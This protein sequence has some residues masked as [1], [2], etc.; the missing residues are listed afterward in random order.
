MIESRSIIKAIDDPFWSRSVA[1]TLGELDRLFRSAGVDLAVQ[2]CKKALREAGLSTK[3]VTHSVAVTSTNVGHPGYDLSVCQKL[4]L[5]PETDRTLLHGVGCAGG[6]SAMRTAAAMAQSY[7]VRARPARILVFACELPSINMRA[8][9]DQIMEQPE[10]IKASPVLYS[11]G[12]A[13]FVLCNELAEEAREKSVYEMVDWETAT[14]ADSAHQLGVT[15]DPQGFVATLGKDV[16]ELALKAIETLFE[17]L[18]PSFGLGPGGQALQAEDFDWALHPGSSAILNGVQRRYGL[19]DEQLRA[20][21]DVYKK[22]GVSSSCTVLVV[23]DKLRQ[24]G[25]GR[26]K[27][28]ACSFGPGITMEMAILKRVARDGE[29]E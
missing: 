11:D 22:Q 8:D 14:I 4:G 26:E 21:F 28:V 15:M 25:Q 10:L 24:M 9:V 27:V 19:D 29:E 16:P 23:L 7:S 17:R 20:S 2:A 18:R 1:P 5:G 3:D 13:A 6:L 12:A